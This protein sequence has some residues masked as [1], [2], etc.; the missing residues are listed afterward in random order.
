VRLNEYRKVPKDLSEA[1]KN[2]LKESKAASELFDE[3]PTLENAIHSCECNRKTMLLVFLARRA[4]QNQFIDEFQEIVKS[5]YKNEIDVIGEIRKD[6]DDP[7]KEFLAV[8]VQSEQR[9]ERI[10]I[11]IKNRNIPEAIE[12]MWDAIGVASS[13]RDYL[14]KLS[15]KVRTSGNYSTPII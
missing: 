5:H 1:I 10:L 4:R 12:H 8:I 7:R 13:R 15:E 14:L 2:A 9:R 3:V 11:D 6:Y